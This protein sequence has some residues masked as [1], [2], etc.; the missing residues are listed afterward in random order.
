MA[1]EW[2]GEKRNLSQLKVYLEEKDRTVREQ[3]WHTT[4]NMWLAKRQEIN[5]IYTDMLTLRKQVA[6][7]AGLADYREYAIRSNERFEYTPEACFTFHEAIAAVVVPAASRIYAKNARRLGLDRLRPWDTDV[8][9]NDAPPLKPYKGQ[10]ALIQGSLNIFQQIDPVLAN[11]LAAMAEEALLDLETRPGKALGGYCT[12][13]A[14]RKRPFI[15]INGTGTQT[16]VQTMFHEAGHAFHVF[17]T[18]DLPFIWQTRAPMEFCEVAS[19]SMELLAAPYIH[20]ENGGFYNTADT[21]RARILHL[22]RFITFLPYM[23]VVDGF[24][25]WVYTHIGEAMD[26]ANCDAAWDRLWA[27]FMPDINWDGHEQARMTGWHRKPHIFGS[28]FYY[29]EY[30]M[31]EVGAL[32]VWRNSLTDQP[33]AIQSYR[34]ALALG[35]T[36]TLPELFAAAGAEFRFDEAMLSSLMGLLEETLGELEGQVV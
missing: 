26:P 12:E 24:Q 28:P 36:R 13:Y 4:M 21:A 15:F 2:D 8:D 18:A 33:A 7:N 19:M 20:Q 29:I 14:V 31:A 32:Q 22:E 9:A 1:A 16:N 5:Q 17:E 34:R 6:A 25:H 23:A 3:V 10:D 11:Y 27:R 30:G 35:G